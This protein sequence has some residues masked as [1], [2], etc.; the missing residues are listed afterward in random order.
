M[1]DDDVFLSRVTH[2]L[3]GELATMVAGIHYLLR[4]ESGIGE[5]GRQMLDRVNGAG[6]RLRRLL[7]ELELSAWIDGA[8]ANAVLQLEPCRLDT[9]VHAA[10]GR[11]ER[12]IAQRRATVE[13][14]V[15]AEVPEIEIDPEIFGAALEHAIDFAVARSVDKTARVTAAIA[16]GAPVLRITD[17]GG[18][19]DQAA[20]ARIF[21]PFAEKDLV[22]RPEPGARRRERLGLGLAIAR[23]IAAAH[24]G[25]LT[26]VSTPG[27]VEMTLTL[28]GPGCRPPPAV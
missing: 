1:A 7:D 28:R 15:P 17:E 14:E 3:R 24:G 13:I 10:V 21:Q 20:L 16:D 18:S 19:L 12:S 22:P 2:D 6:Q 25:T 26:A 4:Y 11:L 23:G 27:G 8:P 5:S 9:A